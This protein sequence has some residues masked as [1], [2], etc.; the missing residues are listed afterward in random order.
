MLNA[1][2]QAAK[3][4]INQL[5][6]ELITLLNQAEEFTDR[7]VGRIRDINNEISHEIDDLNDYDVLARLFDM[8]K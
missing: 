1:K 3:A 2:Q 8:A 4:T 6:I 5:A 7:E